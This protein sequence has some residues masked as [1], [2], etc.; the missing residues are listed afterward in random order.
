MTTSGGKP[1]AEHGVRPCGQCLY[2]AQ[3]GQP[4]GRVAQLGGGIAP[5]HQGLR[6]GVLVG[7]RL[8]DGV[9]DRLH[10]VRSL[11]VKVDAVGQQELHGRHLA[12][13]PG[14]RRG[15][16]PESQIDV[17]PT[18]QWRTNAALTTLTG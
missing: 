6:V 11:Q 8:V 14:N 5:H 15:R 16:H 13:R 2:P 17:Y 18:G 1:A 3:P 10:V 9:D 4:A 12:S 7:D